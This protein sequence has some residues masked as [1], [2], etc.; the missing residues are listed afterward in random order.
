MS[1]RLALPTRL[2]TPASR[3][4]NAQRIASGESSRGRCSAA[5]A[6]WTRGDDPP[7]LLPR[8]PWGETVA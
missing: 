5:P 2:R 1:D 7:P 3:A 6:A 8:G 4:T